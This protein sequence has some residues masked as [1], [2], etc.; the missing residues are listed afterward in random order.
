MNVCGCINDN[1][2]ALRFR[3]QRRRY[4]WRASYYYSFMSWA[5]VIGLV[6]TFT[7]H[8]LITNFKFF[9]SYSC[10]ARSIRM[11][12]WYIAMQMFLIGLILVMAIFLARVCNLFS[13]VIISDSM[14][15]GRVMTMLGCSIKW[16]PWALAAIMGVTILFNSSSLIWMFANSRQ[17][18]ETRFNDAAVNAV[19]NCRLIVSGNVP[20][21]ISMTSG[22]HKEIR[23]CNS[24]R[25]LI[26]KRLMLLA[27][28][29]N[30][31][32][33]PCSVE[34]PTVCNAFNDV[35]LGKSVDWSRGDLRGCLGKV[36]ESLDAF[37]DTATSS[38][39][40]KYLVLYSISWAVLFFILICFFYLM[41]HT[42]EFDAIIYQ[43]K[44]PTENILIK[45]M[46]PL[47]P[48]S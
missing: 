16:L 21:N 38:D 43:A 29:E 12:T 26:N 2:E 6:L 44:D 7:F 10:S 41:K 42:T 46:Q 14:T 8:Y 40:Y 19:R 22:V 23:E 25:Y 48:W 11:I 18:C 28:V 20:C 3:W 15:T 35:L 47:T 9:M 33:L 5:L 32:Q 4:L 36:P 17:W 37:Q 30:T 24:P 1:I 27:L 39:L 45:I 13:N 31:S 34:D